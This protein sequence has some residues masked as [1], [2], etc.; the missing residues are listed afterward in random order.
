[1][2]ITLKG[3]FIWYVRKIFQQTNISYHLIRKTYP[4]THRFA[5]QGLR[6][7]TFFE[8]FAC[9]LNEWSETRWKLYVGLLLQ[10]SE[11]ASTNK[12]IKLSQMKS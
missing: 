11:K 4:D 10:Q 3:L 1:M 12:P 2:H 6:N 5:Y 8:N 7:V 9:V